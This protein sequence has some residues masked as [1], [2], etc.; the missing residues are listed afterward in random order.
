MYFRSIHDQ[1]TKYIVD[2]RVYVQ[3]CWEIHCACL[4]FPLEILTLRVFLSFFLS[5]I[6]PRN[7]QLQEKNHIAINH[8]PSLPIPISASIPQTTPL[9]NRPHDCGVA[10]II[11]I[12]TIHLCLGMCGLERTVPKIREN[13]FSLFLWG[14]F[15]GF[16]VKSA[17]SSA[18]RPPFPCRFVD[19]AI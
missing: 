3:W 19:S 2:F 13:C 1:R 6:F 15:L 7:F 16:G 11:G 10:S 9:S 12:S 5:P 18:Y 4:F 17:M 14:S 8:H